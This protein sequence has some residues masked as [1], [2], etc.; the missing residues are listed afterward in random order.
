MKPILILIAMLL[1]IFLLAIIITFLEQYVGKPFGA[2]TVF[3]II[4]ILRIVVNV[5]MNKETE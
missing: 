1:I 3:S 2:L 4:L 5:K